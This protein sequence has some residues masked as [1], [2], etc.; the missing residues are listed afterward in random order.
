MIWNKEER[1]MLRDIYASLEVLHDRLSNIEK[2]LSNIET[3]SGNIEKRFYVID[4]RLQNIELK[5]KEDTAEAEMP[6]SIL[7]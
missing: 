5:N 3:R 2:R 7:N 6:S 1:E 4:T